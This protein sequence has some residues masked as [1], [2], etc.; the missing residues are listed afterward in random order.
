MPR[1][2]RRPIPSS[3]SQRVDDLYRTLGYAETAALLGVPVAKTR[4]WRAGKGT[5]S[6]SEIGQITDVYARKEDFQLIVEKARTAGR[7]HAVIAKGLAALHR[8]PGVGNRDIGR[9]LRQRIADIFVSLGIPPSGV[10]DAVYLRRRR[11]RRR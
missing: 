7:T 2:R 1:P 10:F 3:Q 6:P 5:I 9:A 8:I 11:R 4:E